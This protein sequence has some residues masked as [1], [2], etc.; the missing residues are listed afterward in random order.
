[1]MYQA[2]LPALPVLASASCCRL[3]ILS[4]WSWNRVFLLLGIQVVPVVQ[5]GDPL[6]PLLAPKPS[7]TPC[8]K[9]PP[10]ARLATVAF[11]ILRFGAVGFRAIY[12]FRTLAEVHRK[13][14][15]CGMWS[16]RIHR[17]MPSS[18]ICGSAHL[19]CHIKLWMQWT[20]CTVS[21]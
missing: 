13:S 8:G 21:H 14:V 9:C 5:H 10:V 1:M 6:W 11:V 18:G 7:V 2:I 3:L 4:A 15:Q 12:R 20:M 19:Y 16:G 17:A